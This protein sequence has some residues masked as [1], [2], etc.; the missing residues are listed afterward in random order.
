MQLRSGDIVR[1]D[2]VHGE[3]SA[4]AAGRLGPI[5]LFEAERII[6]YQ[7]VTRRRRNLFVFRTLV[8]DD[9]LAASVPGVRPRVRLLIY[10]HSAGAIEQLRRLFGHLARRGCD[11]A[12]L[13]DLFYRRVGHAVQRRRPTQAPLRG[14][15][16]RELA[17]APLASLAPRG[18]QP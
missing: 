1:C 15:L 6:A 17:A 5:A 2:L 10:A 14:L 3:P 11:A 7:V 8:V 16:R 13:S 12:C 9:P 18:T 4:I